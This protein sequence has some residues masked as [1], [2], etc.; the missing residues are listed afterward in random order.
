MQALKELLL[1]ERLISEEEWEKVIKICEEKGAKVDEVLI[2]EKLIDE[3]T[4]LKCISTLLNLPFLEKIE[5]DQI[6]KDVVNFLPL[7]FLKKYSILFLKDQ[8][9][10]YL[11]VTSSPFSLPPLEELE[12]LMGK[13]VKLALSLHE[14]IEKGWEELRHPQSGVGEILAPQEVMEEVEES[15]EDLLDLAHKPPIIKFVNLALYEALKMR[16]TDVHIEPEESR[17]RVRYRID[18]VLHEISSPPLHYLPA[19]ISRI[20]VM[21]NLNIAEHRLPQDGR[22]KIKYNG[23]EV[24]VRVSIIPTI[25]G[26]RVVLRLLMRSRLLALEE[27]GMDEETFCIMENLLKLPHGIIL[28]TGPTG[29]GKTTT[30]YAS[31]MRINT[32]ERNI[33]TI[34]DPVEYQIPGIAQIQVKPSIGLTFAE[35]LR[36]VLRHDPDIILVGEMRDR[37]TAEIAIR[38]SLTGHLVFSTLHTNDSAS[39]ITRLLDIGIEPYLVSSSVRA[40]IAQRLVRKICPECRREELVDK[41]EWKKLTN[42]APPEK[43]WKGEGCEKCLGT[44]YFGRT[45]IYEVLVIDE[46]IR[47]MINERVE[48][49]LI[50]KEARKKGMKT[51][52]DDGMIKVKKGITTVEEVLRVTQEI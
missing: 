50:K 16:A 4:L 30:L 36:S 5:A 7:E 11:L 44:G 34:E 23:E 33:I 6:A 48:A 25:W 10:S 24:D 13:E 41:E 38:A 37:E 19:I 8:P 28:V 14:E 51:L 18:G 3:Y 9:T 42:V 2:S 40:I 15:S 46:N 35:G 20:K 1:K 52:I 29:S 43:I 31:L 26:E 32:P 39:A 22:F 47:K 21:A 49:H 17:V 12:G 27:L 45:G